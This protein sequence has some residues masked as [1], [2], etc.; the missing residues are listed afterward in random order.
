MPSPECCFKKLNTTHSLSCVEVLVAI[1]FRIFKKP[2]KFILSKAHA[3]AAL[4]SVL[5]KKGMIDKSLLKTYGKTDSPL[6]VHAE[7]HLVPGVEFSCGS[8]GHGL[9]YSAGVALA[10]KIKDKAGRIFVLVGDGESQ[11][12]SI[13]EA[14]L[15]AANYKLDN[16]VFIID[17]NNIQID[18]FTN[19]VIDIGDVADKLVSSDI[20]TEF[21]NAIVLSNWAEA[22]AFCALLDIVL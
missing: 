15:F 22:Y 5:S 8:L 4:Y 20:S 21:L 14:A 3:S 9:S 16:L 19:D 2:D 12:G 1:Y 13:W 10:N 11:E 6:G 17:R 18:G 7:K